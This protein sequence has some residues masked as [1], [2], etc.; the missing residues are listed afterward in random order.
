MPPERETVIPDLLNLSPRELVRS[1]RAQGIRRF[2]FVYDSAEQGLVASHPI[3]NPVADSISADDRDFLAHEG[4]FF[5]ISRHFDVLHCAFVHKTCRGQAAGGVRYWHYP[6]LEDCIRDGLRLARGMTR[7]NALAGLWWGGGKGVMVHDPGLDKNDPEIRA[8]LYREYGAFMSSLRGC[9]V[10]AEDAGTQE[11]DMAHIYSQTRFTTCIHPDTG[12]SGNP[13]IPTARGVMCGIT[14]ALKFLDQ[15]DIRKK[16]V[17]V[18][19]LGN[20]G[21]RTARNLIDGGAKRVIACDVDPER[22]EKARQEFAGSEFEA[23]S[24]GPDSTDFLATECD[25][26]VPCAT[27]GMLNPVTIPQI[28]ATLVCGAANNQLEDSG[29]D[30]RLLFERGITYIP[31]F[32]TNRMGIV[33]CANEQYGYVNDDPMIERH[34]SVDWEFSIHQTVLRVLKQSRRTGQPPGAVALTLADELALMPHPIHGHRGVRIIRSL[35][36]NQWHNS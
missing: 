36:E 28:Q 19:G 12:G 15:G 9:Y 7:K 5:Q 10:T 11:A 24:V 26:L 33:N 13:G 23:L 2:Y 18:Q 1:F 20:V 34:L 14:A 6:T 32:L 35:V 3:L 21:M 4:L 27:G 16:T 25:V 17:A 22:V 31:D 29:R 30:D 8:T